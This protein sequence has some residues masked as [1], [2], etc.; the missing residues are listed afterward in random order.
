MPRLPTINEILQWLREVLGLE[1]PDQTRPTLDERQALAAQYGVIDPRVFDTPP[2][3][4]EN[5]KP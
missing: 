3:V 1:K 2:N 4:G 5:R